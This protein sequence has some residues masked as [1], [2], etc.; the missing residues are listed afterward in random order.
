MSPSIVAM[1]TA[2]LACI[3]CSA[4][5]K[6][7]APSKLSNQPNQR[8]TLKRDP[9]QSNDAIL[10][11]DE[12]QAQSS[13]A[14]T[15]TTIDQTAPPLTQF[16]IIQKEPASPTNATEEKISN[17]FA[18]WMFGDTIAPVASV[19][20]NTDPPSTTPLTGS[21]FDPQTAVPSVMPSSASPTDS[22]FVV[23]STQP[24]EEW[25]E[26]EETEE[27]T[28]KPSSSSPLEVRMVYLSCL[29]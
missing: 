12:S 20:S 23:E 2:A 6:Y 24:S 28:S 18:G 22:P 10:W 16:S 4:S 26:E 3:L 21:Q 27:P 5:I 17:D 14:S 11:I 13:Q 29:N 19:G 7:A 9:T 8:R 15:K 1:K 25:F